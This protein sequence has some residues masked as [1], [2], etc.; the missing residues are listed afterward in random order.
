MGKNEYQTGPRHGAARDGAGSSRRQGQKH[1]PPRD[2]QPR[3][4]CQPSP[5][6]AFAGQLLLRGASQR[7][8][9]RGFLPGHLQLFLPG[10]APGST[11]GPWRRNGLLPAGVLPEG[12]AVK[13]PAGAPKRSGPAGGRGSLSPV[14]RLL[15][16]LGAGVVYLFGSL[17]SGLIYDRHHLRDPRR[18]GDSSGGAVPP[19]DHQRGPF[20]PGRPGGRGKTSRSDVVMIRRRWTSATTP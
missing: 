3:D 8:A 5:P 4:G 1:C 9:G 16:C 6:G 13:S 10:K 14:W 12:R 7:L 19:Q 15:C 17:L 18:A 11:N 2:R 20:R